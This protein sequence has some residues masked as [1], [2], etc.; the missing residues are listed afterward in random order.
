MRYI[1]LAILLLTASPLHAQETS[2]SSAETI[3]TL[4]L[5]ATDSAS[6]SATNND[7]SG[8]AKTSSNNQEDSTSNETSL[9][10][11]QTTQ[12]ALMY[13]GIMGLILIAFIAGKKSSELDRNED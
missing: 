3:N 5:V 1:F 7:S 10:D 6:K 4:D 12:T 2:T 9:I 11:K 13:S 8:S